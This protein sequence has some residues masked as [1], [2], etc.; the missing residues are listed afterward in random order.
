[1]QITVSSDNQ[2]VRFMHRMRRFRELRR[3][4]PEDICTLTREFLASAILFTF[5]ATLGGLMVA[6]LPMPFVMLLYG[7]IDHPAIIFS[8]FGII[9]WVVIGLFAFLITNGWLVEHGYDHKLDP[10][11]RGVSRFT[12]K[13]SDSLLVEMLRSVKDKTC[14][15]VKVDQ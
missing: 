11:K 8:I 7:L 9:G 14:I 15:R 5:M 6:G 13:A 12:E 10:I 3:P 4:F 1:M 2:I